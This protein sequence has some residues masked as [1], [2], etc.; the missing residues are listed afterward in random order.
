M[1]PEQLSAELSVGL[2][3]GIVVCLEVGYRLGR[4]S[5]ENPELTHEGIGVI[6][7]AVFAPLRGAAIAGLSKIANSWQSCL[8]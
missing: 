1:N 7:A 3:V 6:E 5:S 8:Q 4:R 2:F